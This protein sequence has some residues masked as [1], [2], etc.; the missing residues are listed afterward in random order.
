MKGKFGLMDDSDEGAMPP[1]RKIDLS[2]FAPV[3]KRPT[4]DLAEIDAAAAPHG[5]ISREARATSSVFTHMGRR[6][7]VPAEPARQL[8]VRMVESQ[9]AR[10]VAYADRHQLTYHD[11]IRRL[12]DQAGE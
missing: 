11:A 8:A 10:F 7:A 12:L 1:E 4:M 5:F 6:R 3:Q 9:Y 2:S